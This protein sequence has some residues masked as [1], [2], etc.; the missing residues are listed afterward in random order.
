M[1]KKV[2]AIAANSKYSHSSLAIRYFREN[3]GCD[4]FECSINDNIFDVYSKLFASDYEVYCFSVYIW[5]VEFILKLAPMLKNVKPDVKIIFGGPE[6]GYNYEEMLGKFSFIDGII[7]GEGEYAISKIV[8]GC[9]DEEIPNFV[10]NKQGKMHITPQVK[11]DLSKIKFPYN[12]EDINALKNKIIYFETSR[13]CLFNCSYCLSSSEGKTRNFDMEYVKNGLKFFIDN[14]VPLVKLV[15]RTFNENNERACE[16]LKYIID[17]NQNTKFHFEVSPLL[18]TQEF[19]TLLEKAKDMVQIE[20][21]IQTTNK[22]TMKII[23]RV[24]DKNDIKAKLSMIP[25]GVHTHMDLIA[26]LPEE[27]LK[28]FEDGFNFVY[29]LKPDMLQLGFL[30]LLHNTKLKSEAGDYDIRTTSFPPYE[31]ISTSK[32]SADEIILLK[33][34]EK[35]VDRIYNSGTFKNTLKKLECTNN[36]E[37]YKKIGLKLAEKENKGP[38]SR[39]DLYELILEIFGDIIK[40]ELVTDFLLNNLK[41]PLPDVFKDESDDLKKLHK[42]LAKSEEFKDVKFRLESACGKIFIV[43]SGKVEVI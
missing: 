12:I 13:G 20:L 14:N 17:N 24:F 28:T 7:C 41:A 2:L 39:V 6:A 36:F 4:I 34:T 5:N 29:S 21:G 33:M 8:E 19:C 9:K 16:I 32:M 43:H 27:T 18:I 38:V 15:D 26:G 11:V 1:K 31:V 3:S 42:E 23:R 35:A 25:K 22:D 37:T 30:K 40:E 10:F